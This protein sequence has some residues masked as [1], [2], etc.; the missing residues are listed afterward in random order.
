MKRG[1]V[2]GERP[3]PGSAIRT[4]GREDK[5][6]APCGGRVCP[7]HGEG[8]EGGTGLIMGGPAWPT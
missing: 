5:A 7:G 2:Q 4:S 3:L 1:R 6:G 8:L